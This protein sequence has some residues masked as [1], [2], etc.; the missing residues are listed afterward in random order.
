MGVSEG[1]SGSAGKLSA[2]SAMQEGFRSEITL[3]NRP[4]PENRPKTRFEVLD[5]YGNL[6]KAGF[7]NNVDCKN[8]VNGIY[9]I[10][11]DNKTE[12]FIKVNK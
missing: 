12:K 3:K 8:I 5:A 1:P 4:R 2:R 9:Y 6:L 10:N 11:Y 7:A